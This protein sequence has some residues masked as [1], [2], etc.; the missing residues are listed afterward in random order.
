MKFPDKL[1]QAILASTETRKGITITALSTALLFICMVL[2]SFP[3]YSYQLLSADLNYFPATIKSLT[4]NLYDSAGVLG[5][6]LT[7]IYS[8]IGGIAITNLVQ[9]LRFQGEGWRNSG[10]IAPGLILSGCA[11]CGAGLLGLIGLTGALATLPFEGNLMR[12]GGILL[13]I[14]FLGK[15]GDPKKCEL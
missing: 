3:E 15:S 5:V 4:V 9:Q 13:I 2:L 14:F 1:K 11:G 6:T 10:L 8:L 7:A 12:L